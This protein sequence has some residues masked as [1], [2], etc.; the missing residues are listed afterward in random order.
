MLSEASVYTVSQK[1]YVS[2]LYHQ[3][4]A[5]GE[6]SEFLGVASLRSGMWWQEAPY[7]L[8]YICRR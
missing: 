4:G 2:V 1:L 7:T 3:A 6:V 8:L 5:W